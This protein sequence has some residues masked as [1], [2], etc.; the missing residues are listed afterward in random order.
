MLWLFRSKQIENGE[1]PRLHTHGLID[2]VATLLLSK[3]LPFSYIIRAVTIDARAH[4]DALVRTA[5]YIAL[6]LLRS[7]GWSDE[8]WAVHR[9]VTNPNDHRMVGRT[10]EENDFIVRQNRLLVGWLPWFIVPGSLRELVPRTTRIPRLHRFVPCY[11]QE[12][13]LNWRPLWHIEVYTLYV[14]SKKTG[15][16]YLYGTFIEVAPAPRKMPV[17]SRLGLERVWQRHGLHDAFLR[18]LYDDSVPALVASEHKAVEKQ[19]RRSG[20]VKA[21]CAFPGFLALVSLARRS[22]GRDMARWRVAL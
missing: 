13:L 1:V 15:E 19:A 2:P 11:L 7:S 10:F 5:Q 17:R 3:Y 18:Y 20:Y 14:R 4:V 12:K 6:A 9:L 8:V 16:T 22:R 21:F